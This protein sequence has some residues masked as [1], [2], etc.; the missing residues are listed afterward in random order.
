MTQVKNLSDSDLFRLT[1]PHLIQELD[2]T[3]LSKINDDSIQNIK[4][5][6]LKDIEKA[7]FQR[8]LNIDLLKAEE[9]ALHYGSLTENQKRLLLL[10]CTP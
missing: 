8:I 6:Q 7:D 2:K 1:A 4:A 10:L 3:Q 5:S 9:A